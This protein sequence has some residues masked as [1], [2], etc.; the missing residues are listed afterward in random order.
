MTFV[1]RERE[2]VGSYG[3]EPHEVETVLRMM[4][5]GS[6]VLPH[7]VGDVIPLTDVLDGLTRVQAGR[8]GGSR[9]V[10]DVENGLP[11]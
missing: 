6:L 9:I 7:V 11:R 4:G 5:D 2:V 3:S 10:V 8:T 1:L